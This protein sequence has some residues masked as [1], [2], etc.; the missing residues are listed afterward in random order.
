[1][2][3]KLSCYSN[4]LSHMPLVLWNFLFGNRKG[5]VIVS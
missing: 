5:T 4:G 3:Y 2:P 1:M